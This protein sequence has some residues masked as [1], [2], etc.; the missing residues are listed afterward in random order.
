MSPAVAARPWQQLAMFEL[1]NRGRC[2]VAVEDDEP[3]AG[4]ALVQGTDVVGHKTQPS[5][6]P[7]R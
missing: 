5:G 7:S 3:C 2:A 4:R 1:A 6:T